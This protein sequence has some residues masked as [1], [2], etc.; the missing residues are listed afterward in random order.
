MTTDQGWT[1]FVR[2]WRVIADD[3]I[4]RWHESPARVRDLIREHPLPWGA[5]RDWTWEVIATD[6]AC[7][8]KFMTQGEATRFIA[9]AESVHEG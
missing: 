1:R 8:A 9:L 3:N 7:V 2:A 6:R 5:E 4:R